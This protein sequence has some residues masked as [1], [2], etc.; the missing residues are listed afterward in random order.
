MQRSRANLTWEADMPRF[1]LLGLFFGEGNRESA[2]S[3]SHSLSQSVGIS[4][5]DATSDLGWTNALPRSRTT[6]SVNMRLFL[7]RGR[8]SGQDASASVELITAARN[9]VCRMEYASMRSRKVESGEI[10]CWTGLERYV[11]STRGSS[12]SGVICLWSSSGGRSEGW[13]RFL[14][15][16]LAGCSMQDRSG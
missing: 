15:M 13:S 16:D 5:S 12:G 11:R 2:S 4:S 9:R 8:K 10:I 6:A 1:L 7:R 3:S 14:R